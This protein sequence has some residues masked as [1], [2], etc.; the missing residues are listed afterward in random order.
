MEKS[1][2]MCPLFPDVPCPR[3]DDAA[4]ACQVRFEQNN[5]DPVADFRDYL[6][7]N[8]ALLRAEQQREKTQNT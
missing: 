8:C 3:G 2:A 5:Y 6:M 1:Q 7:L 4:E